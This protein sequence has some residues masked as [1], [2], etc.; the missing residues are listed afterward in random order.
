MTQSSLATQAPVLPT[1]LPPTVLSMFLTFVMGGMQIAPAQAQIALSENSALI[2]ACRISGLIA[3][4]IYSD[5]ARQRIV[6]QL[7]PNTT[8]MLTGVVS[9]EMV[10]MRRGD[11]VGWIAPSTLVPCTTQPPTTQPPI[12]PTPPLANGRR[13]Y[14]VVTSRLE[15]RDR[16]GGTQTIATLFA[17]VKV[18]AA[19]P[20]QVVLTTDSRRWLQVNYDDMNLSRV[21][22]IL[23]PTTQ[24][25]TRT[26]IPCSN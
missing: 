8:V 17:G 16:P 2:N 22:W 12:T 10:Q 13:C 4:P 1:V 11:L 20:P 25:A 14:Q 9:A 5:V 6:S 7:P 26:L 24:G 18:Y 19:N 3:L 23:E 15:V 21:G